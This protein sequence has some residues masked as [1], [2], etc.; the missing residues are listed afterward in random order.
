MK[1]VQPKDITFKQTSM[2]CPQVF[3]VSLSGKE[4]G[5]L[6]L[7]HG[8]FTVIYFGSEK[9]NNIVFF[10]RPKGDGILDVD[11]EQF[12]LRK[13]KKSLVDY[14]NDKNDNYFY[15]DLLERFKKEVLTE[16]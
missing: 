15:L 7:R 16:A 6:R 2:A 4:I 3:E 1:L 5:S 9:P 13:A 12:Y 8:V 11:E 10:D 14:L